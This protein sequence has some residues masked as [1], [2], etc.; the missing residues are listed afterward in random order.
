MTIQITWY[1]N[2]AF[3]VDTDD[4]VLWFDPSV[5]KNADSPIKVDDIK[6]SARFVFTTHGDPGHFINSVQ[7]V[8]KTGAKFVASKELC[9]F[10]IS[11]GQLSED[12]TIPLEFNETRTI[13]GLEV[14]LFEAKHPELTPE[15]K[16]VIRKWGGVETRNAGFVVLGKS[17]SLCLLGDCI[18]SPVFRDIGRKFHID[19][20]MIPIQGKMHVDS[21]PEEAAESGACIIRDLKIR[22]LFPVIQYTKEQNRLEPL[23]WKLN[24]LGV[25]TRLIFD[26]P[27]IAHILDK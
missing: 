8:Q 24:E 3:R 21:T 7:V 10:V 15:L 1:D 13:D 11:K 26:R 16:E 25:H 4:D 6:D 23:K 18:Y 27:G 2:A 5:N 19:I 22:F 20:G 12:Q 17:F 9:D 14:Y